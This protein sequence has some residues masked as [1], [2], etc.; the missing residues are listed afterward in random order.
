MIPLMIAS[1]RSYAGKSGLVASLILEAADRGVKVGY[2][3][4][5]GAMPVAVGSVTTDRDATYLS[6]LASADVPVESLCPAVSTP[7][8]IEAALNGHVQ[9]LVP[10]MLEAYR[11]VADRADLVLIE[12]PGD[13]TQGRA[14]GLDTFSL[15][16]L[17]SCRVVLIDR[18]DR[19][20]VIPD[21]VLHAYDLLG[22]SLMGVVLND[23]PPE[24]ESHARDRIVPYLETQGVRVL[25]VL[26]HDASLSTVTA[27][28][29]LMGV[30]GV[31][32]AA[33]DHL[34]QEVESFMVG[35]MGHERALSYFKR[36]DRKAVITGGD[37]ADVQLAALR[38]D[39]SVLIC[40]GGTTPS[41]TVLGRAEDAGVPVILVEMDTFAAVSAMEETF[42]HV[43]VHD[44]GK[45]ARIREMLCANVD[46]D[47]VFSEL[48][49]A[50]S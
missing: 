7:T 41:A 6:S 43:R 25:G 34:D 11:V 35:A 15:S 24:R 3:K 30:A 9:D 22:D 38:T 33:A 49:A 27:S 39:T 5:F 40:T 48:A 42:G 28:D 23:V 13:L 20:T 10:R 31:V 12:G 29:I 4:P 19:G 50:A 14:F 47:A 36:R 37:R 21:H 16:R 32:L 45:V 46:I 17:L 18:N 2:F 26:A 1:T 8:L 44:A